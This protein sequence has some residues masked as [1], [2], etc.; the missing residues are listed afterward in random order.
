M[1][2]EYREEV[3]EGEKVRVTTMA[4]LDKILKDLLQYET[5]LQQKIAETKENV[6]KLL[7]SS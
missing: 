2:K 4:E 3:K 7:K 5:T 1:F 6:R